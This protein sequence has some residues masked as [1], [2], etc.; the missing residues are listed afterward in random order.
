LWGAGLILILASATAGAQDTALP[1]PQMTARAGFIGIATV[2]ASEVRQNTTNGM[3]YTHYALK[4]I[5]A[6]KGTPLQPAEL[7]QAGGELD[8][9][10]AVIVGHDYKLVPG[11][12]IVL[13]ATISKLG[14]YVVMGLRQGLYEVG[15]GPEHPVHRLSMPRTAGPSASAPGLTVAALKKEVFG[16]LGL[17]YEPPALPASAPEK[18]SVPEKPSAKTVDAP[19]VGPLPPAPHPIPED[20]RGPNW[21]MVASGA[22]VAAAVVWLLLSMKR[23]RSPGD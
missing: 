5:E 4:I 19:E 10:T 3:I 23:R 18:V 9:K 12:T 6:W 21:A 1:V 13:F 16:V 7:L 2:T 15:A 14:N 22:A 17:P 11:Q 20:P 8:G